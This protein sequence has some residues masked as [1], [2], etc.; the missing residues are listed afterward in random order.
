LVLDTSLSMSGHPIKELNAGVE[1]V[2]EELRNGNFASCAVEIGVLTIGDNNRD[3]LRFTPAHQIK[4]AALTR[5]WGDMP[6]DAAVDLAIDQRAQRKPAYS[7]AGVSY[8][9]P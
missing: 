2:I 6:M 1:Q 7:K 3:A 9:Q 8:H 4:D 5:A